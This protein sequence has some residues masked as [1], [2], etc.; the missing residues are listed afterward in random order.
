MQK[1]FKLITAIFVLKQVVEPQSVSHIPSS[2]N[3][4]FK[5]KGSQCQIILINNST[6]GTSDAKIK[7]LSDPPST[8]QSSGDEDEGDDYRSGQQ[9]SSDNESSTS[10]MAVDQIKLKRHDGKKPKRRRPQ[11]EGLSEDEDEDDVSYDEDYQEISSSVKRKRESGVLT[12]KPKRSKVG[13]RLSN[14]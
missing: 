5:P 12:V 6:T 10:S 3:V 13:T 11:A 1:I 2:R 14:A 4:P 8:S 9:T 7:T